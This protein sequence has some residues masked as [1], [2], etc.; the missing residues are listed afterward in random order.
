ME[1]YRIANFIMQ[2]AYLVAH[3]V[4]MA[5][6]FRSRRPTPIWRWF[7]AFSVSL[8]LWVSGRFLE[9]VVYL[10]FP[11]NNSAYVF[12]ANYQYIGVTAA[13]ASYL[14]WNLYLTGK[15]AL[16]SNPLFRVFVFACPVVISTVAFTN[17]LHHLFY[18]KL[19]M[20]QTVGHGPLFA[21]CVL[22]G[23]GV[24]L[25]GYGVALT[26]ILRRGGH[27]L[28]R[29]LLFSTFPLLPAAALLLRSLT[30]VDRLDYTPAVMTV[31]YIC[32]YLVIFKYNYVNIIPAS[33]ETVIRQTAHPIAAY[34]SAAGGYVYMNTAAAGEYKSALEAAAGRV[35]QTR[36]DFEGSFDGKELMVDVAPLEGEDGLLVTVTDTSELS[37]QLARLKAQ[38]RELELL[39][40]ELEEESRNIDAYLDAMY[41]MPGI[42]DRQE[43]ISGIYALISR[44]FSEISENLRLAHDAPER[45]EAALEANL[46]LAESC[47]G[48]IRSAVASLREAGT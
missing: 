6:I 20:G 44:V 31:S 27:K 28:K 46:T 42:R 40:G 47:I 24:L 3:I 41:R 38:I 37:R 11:G 14:T 4:F 17:G 19:V 45:G 16:A 22:W 12:A 25:A 23:Y 13:A 9:T 35:A 5:F 36:E 34:S 7:A 26:D 48:E 32:V 43:L 8:W 33:I 10:F 39:S 1:G 18:T 15:D 2:S 29:L 30:K 21:P